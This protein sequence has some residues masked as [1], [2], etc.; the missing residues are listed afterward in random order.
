MPRTGFTI[1]M[2]LS[3]SSFAT[4][5]AERIPYLLTEEA[6]EA[7]NRDYNN[8]TDRDAAMTTIFMSISI[9]SLKLTKGA[10]KNT[11]ESAYTMKM[12]KMYDDMVF[13]WNVPY[14]W[15]GVKAEIEDLYRTYVGP[16]KSHCEFAVGSGL[17]LETMIKEGYLNLTGEDKDKL[18]LI[19]LAPDTVETAL[20]RL[21][22]AV[23]S[24]FSCEK[25]IYDVVKGEGPEGFQPKYYNSVAA[26]YLF[27]CLHEVDDGDV[28]VKAVGNISKFV[29]PTEGVFFGAT[30]LGKDIYDDDGASQAAKDAIPVM[31]KFGVF[32]NE[33]HS[34]E[35]VANALKSHFDD[36]DVWQTGHT[37]VWTA[38]K[39]KSV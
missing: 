25:A 9:E 36:V 39:P 13:G 15:L 32:D 30:V 22:A 24:D 37:A 17:M 21:T 34:F 33:K 6:K 18:I 7:L 11:S 14:L 38:R 31:C 3:K 19:D 8:K 1:P 12:L 26:N 4:E 27:H 20:Q 5:V 28:I 2:A 23:G 16:S 35:R 29:H 10:D